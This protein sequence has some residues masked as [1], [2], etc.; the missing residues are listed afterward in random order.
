[1]AL[2]ESALS[3][4]VLRL[5]LV[6]AP[7]LCDRLRDGLLLGHLRFGFGDASIS[8]LGFRHGCFCHLENLLSATSVVP[9]GSSWMFKAGFSN[10]EGW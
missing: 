5:F 8:I 2:L 3:H 1:M 9:V 10:G 4:C 7:T 6:L